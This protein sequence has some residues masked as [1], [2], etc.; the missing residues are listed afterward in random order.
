MVAIMR[1]RYGAARVVS[2]LDYGVFFA[3]SLLN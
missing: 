1:L 2:V 3:G